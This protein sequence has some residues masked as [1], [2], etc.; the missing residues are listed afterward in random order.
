[1]QGALAVGAAGGAVPRWG[2]YGTA[3]GLEGV[4]GYAH[5]KQC[6]EISFLG[7]PLPS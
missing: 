5:A 2:W 3:L 4:L 7:E 1:M 6:L